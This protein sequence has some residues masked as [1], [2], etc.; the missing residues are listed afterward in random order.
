MDWK[1]IANGPWLWVC[2]FIS[3]AIGLYQSAYFLKKAVFILKNHANYTDKDI[4]KVVRGAVI[5][6]FGPIVAEIF[7]MIALVVTISPAF[8]FQREG[9]GVGSVFYELLM[10]ENAATAIGETFGGEDF[11]IMGF[12]MVLLVANVSCI[13]WPLGAAFFTRKL[14]TIRDKISGGD[15]SFLGVISICATLGVFGFYAAQ[16]LIKGGGLM[17]S[18]IGGMILAMFF[19][20][21]ADWIHMPRLK[22]W[23][24]GLAMFGGMIIGKLVAG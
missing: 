3:V 11:S 16:R 9:I 22:E 10:V 13:G 2:A 4:I 17:A 6:A 21:L 24:L 12:A 20:K 15:I 19:F 5:T 1:A 18:V 14:G 23:A 8:A 7:V